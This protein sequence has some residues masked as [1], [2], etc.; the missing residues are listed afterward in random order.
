MRNPDKKSRAA[1][2]TGCGLTFPKMHIMIEHRRTN[3][4]GGKYLAIPAR[5]NL[6]KIR[7]IREEL[8]RVNRASREA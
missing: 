4:C 1:Y 5:N 8:A 2:C 6:N 7:L 3:R